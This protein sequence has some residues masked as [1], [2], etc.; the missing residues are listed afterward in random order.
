MGDEIL[1]GKVEDVNSG[2]LCRE[3]HALGWRVLR[4]RCQAA[5]RAAVACPGMR[6]AVRARGSAR[7]CA[8][9]QQRAAFLPWGG[10]CCPAW[11]HSTPAC[12]QGCMQPARS[13]GK[14]PWQ[15]RWSRLQGHR[16]WRSGSHKRAV[17]LQV[18][19]VPDEKAAIAA[20]VSAASAA[21]ELVITAGGVGPTLDDVTMAGVALAFG[22]PLSR[23]VL[24]SRAVVGLDQCWTVAALWLLP[25]VAP[26]R[27]GLMLGQSCDACPAA[28]CLSGVSTGHELQAVPAKRAALVRSAR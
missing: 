8:G 22:Y 14:L 4:V 11:P 6:P 28:A 27:G 20:E 15:G 7:R 25:V 18:A 10:V 9:C 26:A 5:S 16:L 24:C 23:S 1:S 12:Y 2:L 3:L 17:R 19:V 21:C 13:A